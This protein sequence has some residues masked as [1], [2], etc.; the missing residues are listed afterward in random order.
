MHV[1]RH[2]AVP[3][4]PPTP[5][6]PRTPE[7]INELC[8]S[9]LRDRMLQAAADVIDRYKQ[10]LRGCT[11]DQQI[12]LT[13]AMRRVRYRRASVPAENRAAITAAFWEFTELAVAPLPGERASERTTEAS[14]ACR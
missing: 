14:V 5:V 10:A 9:A 4:A 2:D 7:E 1:E 3:I 8:L 13:R 11:P 6:L 12:R